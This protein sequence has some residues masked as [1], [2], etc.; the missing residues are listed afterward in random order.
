MSFQVYTLL[1]SSF[2]QTANIEII[3]FQELEARLDSEIIPQY[4]EILAEN[5]DVVNEIDDLVTR[6]E[7]EEPIKRLTRKISGVSTGLTMK[8]KTMN[9]LDF[10]FYQFKK[11]LSAVEDWLFEAEEAIQ[12][13]SDPDRLKVFKGLLR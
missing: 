6:K 10:K 7:V 1:P 13:E 3:I 8:T 11:D 5:D 12:N 2:I 9:E 4:E